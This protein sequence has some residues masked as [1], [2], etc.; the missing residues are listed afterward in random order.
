MP[1]FDDSEY[2]H[3]TSEELDE[4][5]C[6]ESE[7]YPIDDT[8]EPEVSYSTYQSNQ[9][10]QLRTRPRHKFKQTLK[11]RASTVLEVSEVQE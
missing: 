1:I 2:Q 9:N 7:P 8:Y 6:F 3:F 10:E 11:S 4:D 5:D